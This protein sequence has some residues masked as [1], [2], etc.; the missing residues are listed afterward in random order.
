MN[1]WYWIF[2]TI[3]SRCIW[4]NIKGSMETR[5]PIKYTSR[6]NN[7]SRGSHTTYSW[8]N[9]SQINSIT[10]TWIK[11]CGWKIL[12]VWSVNSCFTNRLRTSKLSTDLSWCF[13]DLTASHKSK[14]SSFIWRGCY[15]CL[16]TK[17]STVTSWCSWRN[18]WRWISIILSRDSN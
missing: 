7:S 14:S 3:T 1:S 16:Y 4:F 10:N 17:T 13:I 5:V 12:S 6:R 8:S 11:A 15:A 18:G 2:D 9:T